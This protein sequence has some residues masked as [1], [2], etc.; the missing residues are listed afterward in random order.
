MAK[1]RGVKR[2][3]RIDVFTELMALEIKLDS[4]HQKALRHGKV[5]LLEKELDAWNRQIYPWQ[6]WS[7]PENS[8]TLVASCPKPAFAGKSKERRLSE[9]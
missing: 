4:L 6:S 5:E 1:I 2:W 3:R 7:A 8:E 9:D